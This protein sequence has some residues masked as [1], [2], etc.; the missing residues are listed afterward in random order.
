MTNKCFN[1]K[2]AYPYEHNRTW[3]DD[4][5]KAYDEEV[6]RNN[7]LM[8]DTSSWVMKM[9]PRFFWHDIKNAYD[10]EEEKKANFITCKC[11]PTYAE[12]EMGDFCGQFVWKE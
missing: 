5:Q 4:F 6:A 10:I 7:A 1:C 8:E 2:H 12:R 11:M 3:N 9:P